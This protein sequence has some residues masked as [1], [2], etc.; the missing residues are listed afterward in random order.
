VVVSIECHGDV[1]RRPLLVVQLVDLLPHPTLG[2]ASDVAFALDDDDGGDGAVASSLA[3][4]IRLLE[5]VKRDLA[6]QGADMGHCLRCVVWSF[7]FVKVIVLQLKILTIQDNSNED[8]FTDST[9][10]TS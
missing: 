2:V 5:A 4:D 3:M 9:T 7:F 8:G 6:S 10:I 1:V